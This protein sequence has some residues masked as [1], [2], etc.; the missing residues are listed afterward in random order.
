MVPEQGNVSKEKDW[1]DAKE[2]GR[3]HLFPALAFEGIQ[4][5]FLNPQV[6]VRA[7]DGNGV[8][9]ERLGL[10]RLGG[11]DALLVEGLVFCDGIKQITF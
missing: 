10:A 6:A 4:K 8:H 9:A 7:R 2:R 11:G 3:D 5:A 1:D